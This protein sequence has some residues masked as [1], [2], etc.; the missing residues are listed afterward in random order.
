M[1]E[2]GSHVRG[3]PD[4][5]LKTQR[6]LEL[7]AE[8]ASWA[9]VTYLRGSMTLI[10]IGAD[11][12]LT[13]PWFKRTA[14]HYPTRYGA[15]LSLND[16]PVITRV[17]IS[18]F[19]ADHFEVAALQAIDHKDLI[20]MGPVGLVKRLH[21]T[22]KAELIE[23]GEWER[24]IFNDLS[25]TATPASHP[26]GQL[27]YII[28]KAD[29]DIFFGGDSRYSWH[30]GQIA[31]RAHIDVALLPISGTAILGKPLVMGPAEALQAAELMHAQY[32]IPIHEGRIWRALP[33][34]W[35]CDGKV[36]ALL[37]LAKRT[38]SPVAILDVAPGDSI[39]FY[40][41]ADEVRALVQ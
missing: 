35:R 19:H 20:I 37:S 33:P 8:T 29:L 7:I 40:R 11:T 14:Y 41:I 27:N 23:L 17:V 36:S 10:E 4:K 32:L 22:V 31:A 9:H 30:V 24:I 2:S 12:I 39:L 34:L 13:D 6:M 16:L 25:F 15:P 5:L 28:D 38:K 1:P 18:H 26:G 3:A 21:G